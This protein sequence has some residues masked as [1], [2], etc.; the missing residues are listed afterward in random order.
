MKTLREQRKKFGITQ[1]TLAD[2]LHVHLQFIS[3]IER[4]LAPL[5][6]RHFKKVSRML[7]IPLATLI[8]LHLERTRERLNKAFHLK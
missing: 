4:G 6:A 5:P 2:R 8:D 7:H 3:N 1:A